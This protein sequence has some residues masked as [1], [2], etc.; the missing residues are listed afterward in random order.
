MAVVFF[1]VGVGGSCVK[2]VGQNLKVLCHHH[3]SNFEDIQ[4]FI[5]P[6]EADFFN[7]PNPSSRTLAPGSTQPLTEMCTRNLP[8]G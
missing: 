5:T 6:D 3:V 2:M 1:F 8:G 4:Y 7:L